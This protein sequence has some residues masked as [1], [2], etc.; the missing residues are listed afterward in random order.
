VGNSGVEGEFDLAK[1]DEMAGVRES[2]EN[3]EDV[4]EM[5]NVAVADERWR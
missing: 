3:M 1:V 4:I 5:G 2:R